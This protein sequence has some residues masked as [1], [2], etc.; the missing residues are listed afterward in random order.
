MTSAKVIDF[1]GRRN[2]KEIYLFGRTFPASLTRRNAAADDRRLPALNASRPSEA[3][4]SESD[5]GA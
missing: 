1:G 2:F 5:R 4:A 3:K